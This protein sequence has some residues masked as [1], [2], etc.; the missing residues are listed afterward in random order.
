MEDLHFLNP[1]QDIAKHTTVLPHWEQSRA[2][3]FVTFR[4][5]DSLPQEKLDRWSRERDAWLAA[6]PTPRTSVQERE[7]HER[8]SIALE[9]WL[10]QG[11]GSCLLKAPGLAQ[12]VS[13]ALLHFHSERCLQHSFVVMPNHVH[14]LFTPLGDWQLAQLL[15]SWKSFTAHAIQKHL[16]QSGEVWQ[17]DY[18]DRII[19]DRAHFHNCVR[20]IRK[21][22]LKAKLKPDQYRLFESE[23][24]KDLG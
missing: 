19:R 12:V 21:N 20:Y 7:Y 13:E 17:R 11:A 1:L 15:H 22:P 9:R 5:A 2:T 23:W 8:F 16:G 4:L 24:V 3:Y 18:F 6:N 14:A 10:D